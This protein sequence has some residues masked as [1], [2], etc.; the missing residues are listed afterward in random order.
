[1]RR[2]RVTADARRQKLWL[3]LLFLLWPIVACTPQSPVAMNPPLT[4]EGEIFLFLQPMGEKAAALTFTLGEVAVRRPDGVSIP[5]SLSFKELVG[6]ARVHS[7]SLLAKA[8]VPAGMYDGLSLTVERAEIMTEDGPVALQIG[9]EPV[10]LPVE[11]KIAPKMAVSFF[12]TFHAG[13]S[14]E[15]HVLFRPVFSVTA[16]SQLPLARLGYLS[17]PLANTLF[18][19]H[20]SGMLITG[21]I[22]TGMLPRGMAIDRKRDRLYTA[23]GESAIAVIDML[24]HASLGVIRLRP[25]DD[26]QEIA[27]SPDGTSLVSANYGSN[28][29]S[30]VDAVAQVERSRVVVG[31][32][33]S[34]VA[35]SPAGNVAYS[36]D[37]LANTISVIDTENL[38]LSATIRLEESPLKGALNRTGSELYVITANSP[39]LLVID[40]SGGGVVQK[41]FIGMGA[42][43]ILVDSRSGFVYVGKRDG[44]I[45]V[46]DPTIRAALDTIQLGGP[47]ESMAIS[48][49]ENFLFALV[50]R[51]N[52][53]NKVN[54]TSK[55]VRAKIDLPEQGYAV[56]LAGAR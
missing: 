54:L 14:L 12:L 21:V 50:P 30:I 35:F 11:M 42:H 22:A 32:G 1:M 36:M 18:V 44:E 13:R 41:I 43:S 8:R 23:L 51:E 29:V 33:P 6:A 34:A 27:L 46:V 16:S 5:L 56:S 48:D 45:S 24:R 25:G 39:N 28:T 53:L 7:Q 37:S 19:F 47:V 31:D 20:D 52:A 26:P 17:M 15:S 55:E 4:T 10:W 3:A 40:L 2:T 49:E 38:T 9:Q